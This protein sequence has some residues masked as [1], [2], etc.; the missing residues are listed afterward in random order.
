[1]RATRL[2]ASGHRLLLR[3]LECALLYHHVDVLHESLSARTRALA[4]GCVLTMVA[5]AG[6][7]FVALLRPDAG[8][9]GAPIALGQES[10]ALF[11]RVGDAW[12]P[13]LNLASA[14]LIAGTDANPKPVHDAAFRHTKRGPL[15]G[16]P[17]APQLLA[18]PLSES[19]SMWTICDSAGKT[20]VLVGSVGEYSARVAPDQALLVRAQSGLPAQLLYHGRRA[21]V[22]LADGA[23]QRALRLDGRTPHV[24]A[25]ALLAAIP[26][27]P[28]ISAPRIS[29][30][31][32]RSAALP[33]FRVGTVLR[34]TRAE[35]DE[36]FVVLAGGV[37]RVGQVV[38]DLLRFGDAQSAANVVAV[39]PDVIRA[40]PV[41]DTL[42]VADFPERVPQLVDAASVCVGWASGHAGFLLG[43]GVPLPDGQLPVTL[44]QADGPGPALDEVY[45]PP[46]RSAFAAARSLSGGGRRAATRYLV[47]DTGVRFAIG[48]D[49]A[50]HDLGLTAQ[51]VP[52]PWPVLAMLPA[53]PELTKAK[54]S[55]ARDTIGSGP[56]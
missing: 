3:R 9:G 44:A 50:A 14:R 35:G 52:A 17:G 21:S 43:G 11:V 22:D 32:G 5:T 13:V 49:Q 8:L 48:D 31:G 46:G 33:G 34:I 7:A 55:V 25:P 47:T 20:T 23:V 51:A 19:E 10:G 45:L 41:V 37:Q 30:A 53:G 26:E 15:L 54:A 16:I 1:M 4:V 42:P 27:A 18:P 29:G 28:P 39:A 40:S 36:Y 12:H 2:H 56:P 24:V 38:A 6:C